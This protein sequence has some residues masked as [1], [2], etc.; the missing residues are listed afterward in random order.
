MRLSAKIEGVP[1]VVQGL[2]QFQKEADKAVK[3]GVDRTALAVETDAKKKLKSDGHWITGRLG[4]SIHAETQPNQSFNYSDGKGNSY[5][6]SLEEKIAKDE[7][8]V[9]TNVHYGPHIE[10]GTR[11]HEIKPVNAK[12]LSWVK[13][14]VRY[15]AK[16]VMHPGTK[17]SSFLLYAAVKQEKHLPERITEELNKVISKYSAK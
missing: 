15:F 9:G 14:G 5:N 1:E 10:F 7:A 4:S 16:R 3:K 17:A 11:A 13:D 2:R 6:G 12:M 8:I